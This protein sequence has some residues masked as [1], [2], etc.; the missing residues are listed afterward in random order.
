MLEVII[1]HSNTRIWLRTKNIGC[2]IL[3]GNSTRKTGEFLLPIGRLHSCAFD[4]L[5]ASAGMAVFTAFHRLPLGLSPPRL[6]EISG[7]LK[8]SSM[9]ATL[10]P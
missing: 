7:L 2:G 5:D 1:R 8:K 10:P 9:A 4:G 6:A 3:A